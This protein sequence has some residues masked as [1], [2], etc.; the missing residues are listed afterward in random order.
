LI[1]EYFRQNFGQRFGPPYLVLGEL[2]YLTQLTGRATIDAVLNR[3]ARDFRNEL[4][5]APLRKD[6]TSNRPGRNLKPDVLGIAVMASNIVLELVEVTTFDQAASTLV[7]DV[8]NKLQALREKVITE[9]TSTL[10]NQYYERSTVGR[11]PF[12]VGPSRWRPRWDQM[13]FPLLPVGS[14]VAS[15]N[16]S[17][18]WI[19]Y[20]PTFRFNPSGA[21][22]VAGV[23]GLILY[24][25]HSVQQPS[26]VP[27]EVLDRLREEAQRKAAQ[28][29]LAARALT[30]APWI[31]DNY[32]QTNKTDKDALLWVAGIGGVALLALLAA[33]LWPVLVAYAS[34]VLPQEGIGALLG[35]AGDATIST[36]VVTTAATVNTQTMAL[37]AQVMQS[38]GRPIFYGAATAF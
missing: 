8:G 35:A 28:A 32:W 12:A 15:Q 33:T 30:L 37:A 20:W 17:V 13:V 38:L 18:E 22:G 16:A 25:I 10:D 31:T 1:W 23:D 14:V 36:E 11:I 29:R 9:D 26:L 4:A 34:A 24:E 3:M 27:K 5:K 6:I 19:C 21:P 7:Q 2:D